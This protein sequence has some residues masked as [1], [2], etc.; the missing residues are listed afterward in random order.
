MPHAFYLP[1]EHWGNICILSQQ[2]ARHL[3]QVLRITTGEEV[4]LL[5]GMGTQGLCRVQKIGKHEVQ[6]ELFKKSFSPPP[7]S[8][9][10]MA[11]AWSKA[12]RR[13]FFMEKAV[14]LGVHEVWLWQG[15][16]SQGRLPKDVKEHWQGQFIAS[17]KQCHNPWLPTVRVF[18]G[19]IADVITQSVSVQHK[20]LPW[21][22]QEHVPMLEPQHIGQEGSSIYVIGPEG[23]FS[24]QELDRL[25]KASFQAVSLGKRILRCETAALLCLGL[26]WW[27]SHFSSNKISPK[28]TP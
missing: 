2:E 9:P 10:I 28:N 7:V 12:T 1:A 22:Q 8:Q 5:D 27:A 21:E 16:H 6:L 24:S 19:G 4:L 23:G 20:F 18:S 26:H 11:L 13:G 17:I 14:E 25:N 15:D 3:A